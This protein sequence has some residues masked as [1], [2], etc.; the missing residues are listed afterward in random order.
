[1]AIQEQ[2][3][4]KDY[5]DHPD[6]LDLQGQQET[7]VHQVVQVHQEEMAQD[8]QVCLDHLDCLDWSDLRVIP[9]LQV[10][11]GHL[12]ALGL[13]EPQEEV[14]RVPLDQQVPRE[15][16]GVLWMMSATARMVDVPSTVSIRLRATTVLAEVGTE[17]EVIQ[18]KLIVKAARHV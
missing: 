5:L 14:Y 16:V 12:E 17:L 8:L 11:K 10:H 3:D 18:D 6:D 7:Q 9:D 15:P 1:M 4:L 2:L 13:V